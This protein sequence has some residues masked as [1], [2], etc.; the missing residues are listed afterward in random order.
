MTKNSTFLPVNPFSSDF[1]DKAY[2]LYEQLRM[3][4]PVHKTVMPNG[5]TAWIV[6]R[7]EDAASALK[8][9]RL[10]KNLFQFV[11]PEETGVPASRMDLLFRHMLNSDP[12]DHTR[13]RS[14]VQKAF[15][16]RMIENMR[17]RVQEISDWLIDQV[18]TQGSMELIRDYA[19]PLPLIVICDMLGLPNEERDQFRTWSHA[20][21]SAFNYPEKYKQITSEIDEFT[22]YIKVLIQRCRLDPQEDLLSLLTQ[23]ES[24][25]SKLSEHELVSMIFLLIVAGHETTVNLIGNGTFALLQHRDQ[26]EALRGNPALI[27]SAIEELLRFMGP[28]EFATNR[29]VGEDFEWGG[30]TIAKGD[31]VLIALASA[32]RDPEYFLHPERLDITRGNNHHIAFG[33]GIHHCLGAPLARMEGRIAIDT[34]LRRLSNMKLAV[35]PDRLKWQPTFIMRGFTALP[36]QFG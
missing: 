32:N 22:S 7:Y 25:G 9:E 2:S 12:P 31:V 13:L 29:W 8:N 33:T 27:H 20:M 11:G 16:P 30:K 21:V 5:N 23:A 1:K 15:T 26:L 36:V 18:E 3:Q 35:A 28:V 19:Y 6:S 10:K 4:D 14:L 17:G 34:L 24:E